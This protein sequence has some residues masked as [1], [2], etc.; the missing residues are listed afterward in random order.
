M[1]V[2]PDTPVKPGGYHMA[3]AGFCSVCG[4]MVCARYHP[5]G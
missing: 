1:I 3:P 2:V 5:V 4:A